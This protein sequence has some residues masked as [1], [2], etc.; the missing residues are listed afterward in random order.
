MKKEKFKENLEE[1]QLQEED[2]GHPVEENLDSSL[3]EGREKKQSE[4]YLEMLQR[5]KAEFENYMKRNEEERKEFAKYAKYDLIL[6]LLN[7]IDDFERALQIKEKNEDFVKGIEMIFKQL[8]K[9]LDEEGVRPIKSL[10]ETFDP[11]K[12]DVVGKVEHDDHED[13]IVEE[14][15]RGYQLKDKILRPSLVKVSKLKEDKN[16]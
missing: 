13:V 1:E 4:E 11:Y 16:G 2:A 14:I 3:E 10:G 12:H 9:T 15:K 6:K 5:L 7:I 8:Q